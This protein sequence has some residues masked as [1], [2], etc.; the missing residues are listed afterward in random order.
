MSELLDMKLDSI[1]NYSTPSKNNMNKNITRVRALSNGKDSGKETNI[2]IAALN[3]LAS[4]QTQLTAKIDE[5][6]SLKRFISNSNKKFQNYNNF[7]N[8]TSP[9]KFQKN[10]FSPKSSSSQKFS[11]PLDCSLKNNNDNNNNDNNNNNNDNNS[12]NNDNY[13]DNNS[14][15]DNPREKGRSP[16]PLLDGIIVPFRPDF[17]MSEK[18]MDSNLDNHN[19]NDNNNNNNMLLYDVIAVEAALAQLR[20]GAD[21]FIQIP[22]ST[23]SSNL[24]NHKII[25]R[26]FSEN[27]VS[28]VNHV[29]YD[30]D[31]SRDEEDSLSYADSMSP[32]KT[33]SSIR[34]FMRSLPDFNVLSYDQ[35]EER[36]EEVN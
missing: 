21:R 5:N 23:T 14:Q 15:K 11:T 32:M 4:I 36:N 1:S 12:N 31:L 8:S 7:H 2:T 35:E 20:E 30:M 18:S 24:I 29:F 6:D 19:N 10:N 16:P 26:R 13:D 33:K 22:S 17:L 9:F 3:E 27:D 34:P 28:N 25:P